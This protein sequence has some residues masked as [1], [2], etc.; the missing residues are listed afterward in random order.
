MLGTL[1]YSLFLY[2]AKPTVVRIF[3]AKMFSNIQNVTLG[4]LWSTILSGTDKGYI[5]YA[6]I[7]FWKN[8][9]ALPLQTVMLCVLVAVLAPIMSR[10]GLIAPQG[11]DARLSLF[12]RREKKILASEKVETEKQPKDPWEK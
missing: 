2:R 11:K 12:W 7:S 6:T 8:L 10:M 4:A 5:Y 9:I 3:L 1:I